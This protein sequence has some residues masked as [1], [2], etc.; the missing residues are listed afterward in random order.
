MQKN[1]HDKE[2]ISILEIELLKLI[3]KY[4][5]N[6]TTKIFIIIKLFRLLFKNSIN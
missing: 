2:K 5:Y 4:A 3:N 1:V 6:I